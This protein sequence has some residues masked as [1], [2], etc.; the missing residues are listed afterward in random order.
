MTDGWIVT[1]EEGNEVEVPVK[2]RE[3]LHVDVG[4]CIDFEKVAP[5]VI[6]VKKADPY[7]C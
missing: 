5:G 3:F 2:I 1:L 6:V 4:D 7:D